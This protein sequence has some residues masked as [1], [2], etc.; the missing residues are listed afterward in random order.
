MHATMQTP[1]RQPGNIHMPVAPERKIEKGSVCC[2]HLHAQ[3]EDTGWD[4]AL[5][6]AERLAANNS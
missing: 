4:P 3:A 5:P 6:A 1:Q 2:L